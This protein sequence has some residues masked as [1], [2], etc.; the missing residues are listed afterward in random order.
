VRPPL[1]SLPCATGFTSTFSIGAFPA[2]LPELGAG[3]L[4]DWQLGLVAAAFGLTRMLADVPVGL[5]LTHHLRSALA[6]G[7]LVVLVGLLALTLGGGSLPVLVLGRA[8]M[9][10]GH[11]LGMVGG[12]TAIL[13][14]QTRVL[15]SAL[16]A[17]ELSAILGMLGGTIVL[18]VLPSRLPWNVALLVTCMP[19]LLG[20][21]LIPAVLAALPREEPGAARP[22]FARQLGDCVPSRTLSRGV[23]LA[24]V[25]GGTVAVAYASVEQFVIP[26]RASREFGL[27]RAGVAQLLMTVQLCDIVCLLPVGL[28]A[29]R[30][31]GG[32]IL[33][34]SLFVFGAG[35]GLVAFGDLTLLTLGCALFGMGMSGWTLP[36][37]LLRR[38]TAPGQ[39]AW[40]TALYRVGVDGGIFLGPLLSGLLASHW[41]GLL[42]GLLVLILGGV[43]MLLLPG[44]WK[45]GRPDGGG[46]F[47][48]AA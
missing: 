42:P 24:F 7:P 11:A 5:F 34:A 25:T 40:R 2:L 38:D 15:G 39:L 19:Q 22:L 30:W 41:P 43:A 26:L 16:N 28:L 46:G 20:M 29:D 3:R 27:P 13:R 6:L 18:A 23:V 33:S 32:R 21:L 45:R 4:A 17:Y 37:G 9:G 1:I 48:R 47:R 12:L 31:G 35:V 44:E 10:A 14:H 36:L 8:V